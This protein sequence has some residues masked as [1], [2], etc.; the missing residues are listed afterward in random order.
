VSE[1]LTAQQRTLLAEKLVS[2][3]ADTSDETQPRL[4]VAA[5]VL[6]DDRTPGTNASEF[7]RDIYGEWLGQGLTRKHLHRLDLK[8]YQAYATWIRLHP[9]QTIPELG[10][11]PRATNAPHS[12]N[13]A[14]TP[15]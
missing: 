3:C 9:D 13:R 1:R 8:L 4:P 14:A 2:L 15:S 5:P 10:T 7:I 6:W 11:R 12:T